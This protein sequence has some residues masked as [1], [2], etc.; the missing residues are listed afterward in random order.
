M[1]VQS[2]DSQIQAALARTP[3]AESANGT[4]PTAQAKAVEA[5]LA[6]QGVRAVARVNDANNTIDVKRLLID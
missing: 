4:P 6:Q 1:Q 5:H 2:R 3:L